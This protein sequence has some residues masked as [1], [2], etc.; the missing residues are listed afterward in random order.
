MSFLVYCRVAGQR[1]YIHNAVKRMG[2]VEGLAS[3][4]ELQSYVDE[5]EGNLE[6]GCSA[7]LHLDLLEKAQILTG[8]LQDVTQYEQ[9]LLM[10]MDID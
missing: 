5:P 7:K 2:L 9:A 10:D 6:L 3:S 1:D 4:I 8:I